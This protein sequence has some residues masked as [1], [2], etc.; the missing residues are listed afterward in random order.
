MNKDC[1]CRFTA[2]ERGWKEPRDPQIH[3]V[4]ACGGS[5]PRQGGV[6]SLSMEGLQ[7]AAAR[8]TPTTHW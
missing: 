5:V 6:G 7:G 3:W 2:A 8:L 1:C 4:R